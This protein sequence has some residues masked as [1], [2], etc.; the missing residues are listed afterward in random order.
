M[1]MSSA[2]LGA[3]GLWPM[4]V[5]VSGVAVLIVVIVVRRGRRG[6]VPP[7]RVAR[8][9]QPQGKPRRPQDESAGVR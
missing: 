9:V 3:S 7:A 6:Q 5:V 1:E 4:V 8:A 2:L